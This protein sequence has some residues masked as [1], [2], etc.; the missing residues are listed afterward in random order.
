MSSLACH[1]MVDGGQ[2][3][4]VVLPIRSWSQWF[5]HLPAVPSSDRRP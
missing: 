3:E 4:A 5:T 1:R 2:A